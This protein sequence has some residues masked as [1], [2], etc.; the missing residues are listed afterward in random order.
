MCPA[1]TAEEEAAGDGA[2][3]DVHGILHLQHRKCP[4]LS[5]SH[6]TRRNHCACL[7]Y[8]VLPLIIVH[9]SC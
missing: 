4:T 7:V 5:F 3:D 6:K 8:L 9:V 2:E 1:T